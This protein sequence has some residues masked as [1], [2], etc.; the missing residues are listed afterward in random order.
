[1]PRFSNHAHQNQFTICS[2]E[3]CNAC[4]MYLV[5]LQPNSSTSGI[6]TRC[7]L[8]LQLKSHHKDG[9]WGG[10][11]KYRVPNS[12]SQNIGIANPDDVGQAIRDG[13][14]SLIDVNG[15]LFHKSHNLVY[16]KRICD[17]LETPH[18]VVNTTSGIC[19]HAMV[20]LHM[21]NAMMFLTLSH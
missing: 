6:V 16:D 17:I 13:E 19:N 2:W 20:A 12:S 1:M 5:Q 18:F 3:S 9:Y 10:V 8:A 4:F 14:F 11:I 7:P 15:I 21:N